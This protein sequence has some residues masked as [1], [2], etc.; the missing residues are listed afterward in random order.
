MDRNICSTDLTTMINSYKLSILFALGGALCVQFDQLRAQPPQS[1][2]AWNEKRP[3]EEQGRPAIECDLSLVGSNA[4]KLGEQFTIEYRIRVIAAAT[5]LYNP[6]IDRRLPPA[7][8]LA[9]F[10]DDKNYLGD[11]FR[12]AADVQSD[13]SAGPRDWISA[14]HKNT[15]GAEIKVYSKEPNLREPPPAAVPIT[16][17]GTYYLQLIFS[18][19]AVSGRG[20]EFPKEAWDLFYRRWHNQAFKEDY[21]RSNVVKLIVE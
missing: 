4:V 10:D 5:S 9:V 7:A 1:R 21:C 11:L 15:V 8:A 18:E 2:F 14:R 19:R 3:P 13:V 6:F 12:S 20:D 16:K 17:P